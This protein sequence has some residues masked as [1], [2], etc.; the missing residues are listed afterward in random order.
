MTLLQSR[1]FNSFSDILESSRTLRPKS[2]EKPLPMPPSPV[3]IDDVDGQ[4]ITLRP[5][6][7]PPSILDSPT[8]VSK[9][10]HALQELLSSERAYASDLI[11]IRDIH[12][13]LALGQPTAFQAA[14]LPLTPP[15]SSGSSAR[16]VST[17]S[18]SSSGSFLGSAMSKE[19]SKIIFNNVG[20]LAEFSDRFSTQLEE[21]LGSVL[22]GGV[23]EDHVGKLFLELI[24]EMEPLYNTYITKHSAALEHLNSL[25]QTPALTAYLA[26]SKTLAQSLTHAWDL[27]SL[28][29]KPVQRLLKYSLLLSAIIDGTPDSHGDKKALKEARSRM[30]AVA[31]GVNEGRRRREVVKEVLTG[32]PAKKGEAKKKGLNIGVAASVNLGRMK[33]LRTA[34]YKAKEGVDANQEAET[35]EKLGNELKT[36]LHFVRRFAKDTTTWAETVT[37]MMKQLQQWTVGFGYVLGLSENQGSDAFDAFLSVIRD[38]LVPICDELNEVIKAKLLTE[39]SKLRDASAPPER[40]LEAMKTLEP[41]HY[42]LLNVN[43]SKSRPSPQ[44]LEASQSYVAIRAQLYDELPKFLELL[45]K[46]ITACIIRFAGWQAEFYNE[47]RDRWGELWDALKVEGE[48]QGEAP[49]TLRVWWSRFAE[50]EAHVN[51]LNIVKPMERAPR[52][53]P[54]EKLRAKPVKGRK[55]SLSNTVDTMS[56][57]TLADT[58]T[59]SLRASTSTH[60]THDLYA[61]YPETAPPYANG[62]GLYGNGN[63]GRK[64]SKES[65]HSKKSGKAHRHTH[66]N[67]SDFVHEIPNGG[68]SK[69]RKEISH[70]QPLKK[71]AS[72]GRLLDDNSSASSSMRSLHGEDEDDERGRPSRK[73]SLRRRLT[74]TLRASP[75]PPSTTSTNARHRR[76]PSLPAPTSHQPHP[77]PTPSQVSFNI[78]AVTVTKSR[79]TRSRALYQCQVIFNCTPPPDVSYHDLPFFTLRI[80]EVYDVLQELG[81]PSTHPNLPLYVDD[82]ED[83]LLLVRN[84]QDDIGWALASFLLP[85]D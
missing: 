82:G 62:H 23:G 18:D 45:H 24:P 60:S 10:I 44:L 1:S 51:S 85:V 72:Q 28:L 33:S 7:R 13:P 2:P 46:G 3:S 11:L 20:E 41:Y 80:G 19:D 40:L 50:V 74:D 83:C 14:S 49:E 77:S 56:S 66:S 73:P 8:P 39:L 81:H 54:P 31:H 84:G 71:S 25:P 55:R 48:M 78:P 63:M 69:N 43:V 35:V 15:H 47:V 9:R 67:A 52:D 75:V 53:S 37:Q 29:I 68:S 6:S 61:G 5:H 59:P 58:S 36:C 34:T 4:S 65:L 79:P 32:T 26:H 57:L 64:R 21:A 30:E 17:A 22:E 70:P 42:G 12:I 16:T 27:P 38:K 76:S